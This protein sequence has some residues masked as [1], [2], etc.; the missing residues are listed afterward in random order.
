MEIRIVIFLAFVSVSVI[1]NTLVIFFAYKVFANLTLKVTASMAEFQKSSE[2]REW[3]DSLQVAADRAAAVTESTKL[4]FAEFDPVLER[5]QE[6]YRRTLVDV[7][8]KLEEVA[9][10]I[11][12]T[13]QKVR[14]IIAKP[15]FSVA[16]FAAGVSQVL[17][18][19]ETEE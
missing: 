3:I 1:F 6:N 4:K 17:H 18:N 8:A 12:T 16:T 19:V 5:T 2:T 10:D 13:V 9:D 14:D 7:D 11:N 15:A